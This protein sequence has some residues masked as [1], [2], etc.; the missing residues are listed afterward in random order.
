MMA[1]TGK[2]RNGQVHLDSPI[3]WPDGTTVTLIPNP[4]AETYSEHLAKLKQSI[5]DMEAGEQGR[6]LREV[7]EEISRERNFPPLPPG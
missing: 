7:M 2:I 6:P 4:A 1:T 3:H 5:A